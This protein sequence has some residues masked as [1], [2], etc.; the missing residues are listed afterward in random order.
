MNSGGP[1]NPSS[2]S[3]SPSRPNPLP[4][5]GKLA[6]QNCAGAVAVSPVAP[7]DDVNPGALPSPGSSAMS[8]NFGG[9]GNGPPAAAPLAPPILKRGAPGNRSRI[10]GP[11][12][13]PPVNP[14][15]MGGRGV[16]AGIGPIGVTGILGAG[17]IEIRGDTNGGV[18]IGP[19]ICIGRAPIGAGVTGIGACRTGGGVTTGR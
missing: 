10:A 12:S 7:L 4:Q 5:F 16:G 17:G 2:K 11:G 14:R 15:A 13:T 9:T 1:P 19:G 6:M 3:K 8:P 18:T